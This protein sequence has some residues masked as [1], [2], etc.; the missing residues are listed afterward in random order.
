[1]AAD[2]LSDLLKKEKVQVFIKNTSRMLSPKQSN[3]VIGEW[4]GSTHPD[5]I[6]V[7]GGHL[8]SWDVG[9][10]AH[11]DGTGCV[12]AIDALRI[13]KAIGYQPKRTL[14]A[15]MFMNEEN[16][17]GGGRA[18]AAASNEAGEF[19]LAA[20]ESD[21]GGFSP[22]GFSCDASEAVF[23]SRFKKLLERFSLLESYDLYIEKGGAG[24]DV[25]PLKSQNGLLIGLRPDSQRYFDYHHTAI[26]TFDAVNQRELQLG[27]AAMAG[28]IYL[29]DQYGL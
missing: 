3:N 7:I 18:Y 14:R 28:L 6:I 21:A 23:T 1:M 11:D 10:G 25:N 29:I 8:D 15:V 24:A 26:D 20:I 19:H 9:Q 2:Q 17:L 16:G 22:R 12:Q 27:A 5:E 4:K 13:L